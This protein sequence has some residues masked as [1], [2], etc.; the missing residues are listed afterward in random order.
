MTYNTNPLSGAIYLAN[1]SQSI[2]YNG[3]KVAGSV[4]AIDARMNTVTLNGND[5]YGNITLPATQT[6]LGYLYNDA[7]TR[8]TFSSSVTGRLVWRYAFA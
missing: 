6:N 2:I 7:Q 4:L 8:F 3:T 5:A 1:T